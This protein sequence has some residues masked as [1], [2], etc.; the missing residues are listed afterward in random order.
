MEAATTESSQIFANPDGTFTQEMNATPVR[1]QRP[2]GSWAPI[3]TSL[4]RE[5]YG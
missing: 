2:D 4:L 3:D 5:A 1:A